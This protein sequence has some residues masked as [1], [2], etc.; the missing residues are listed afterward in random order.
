MGPDHTAGVGVILSDNR[1]DASLDR[2]H[3]QIIKHQSPCAIPCKEA[4]GYG[5]GLEDKSS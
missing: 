5:E 4:K 3:T 1:D 2:D